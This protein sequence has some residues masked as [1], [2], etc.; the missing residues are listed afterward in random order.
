MLEEK[1]KGIYNYHLVCDLCGK[2][3]YFINIEEL[4][5][6]YTANKWKIDKIGDLIYHACDCC[7]IERTK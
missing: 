4:D 6:Y 1:R 5:D 3:K 7:A 2:E